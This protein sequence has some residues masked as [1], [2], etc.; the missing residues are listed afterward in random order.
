MTKILGLILGRISFCG[1]TMPKNLNI[2]HVSTFDRVGG[3]A[4]AANRLSQGLRDIGH[5]S[6][7]GV[8]NK[9]ADG[10][11]SFLLCGNRPSFI[12]SIMRIIDKS[13]LLLYRGLAGKSVFNRH[14]TRT[15]FSPLW[16][17]ANVH[18][19]AHKLSPD[20]VHLHWV[21]DGFFPLYSIK[22]LPYPIVWTMHDCW[23]FTGGCHLPGTCVRYRDECG[24]CVQLKSNAKNDISRY[25]HARKKDI[26]RGKRIIFAAPSVMHKQKAE[27]SSL[28]A[29]QRIEVVPNS[30]D[31]DRFRP[32][33]KKEALSK[34][35]LPSP[36]LVLLFG[37]IAATRD[38]NK[39]YDIL[40]S[41][42]KMLPKADN[43]VFILVVGSKGADTEGIPY[44]VRFL[45]TI[46]DEA[47]MVSAYN[48]ADVFV[49]T[50]R[51]E[52]FSLM[53]L[54]ALACGVPVAGFPVGAVPEMV[55]HKESGYMAK[56]FDVNDLAQGINWILE[57]KERWG[58]LSEFARQSVEQRFG[59]K[60]V[61]YQYLSLY[62]ELLGSETAAKYKA[63]S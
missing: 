1:W 13:P 22:R 30:V 62:H 28:L 27:Q 37:G 44:P 10:D 6:V 51:E 49:S 32:Q 39:G 42:L 9:V 34:F 12:S 3:A 58:K 61:A 11:S 2:L 55:R 4:I 45:G 26:I 18:R 7:M 60:S 59:L 16:I 8:L 21:G 36:S 47:K 35:G 5:N 25:C 23:P 17:P 29:D 63:I 33:N 24:K 38:Q 15:L 54:E 43:P 57:D 31:M 19:H 41:A 14:D 48:A 53:T 20:I 52:S 56:S 46:S 40:R 50:S